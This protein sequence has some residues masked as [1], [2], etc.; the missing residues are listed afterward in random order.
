MRWNSD[1]TY[2]D[3]Y[4]VGKYLKE[5]DDPAFAQQC[6]EAILGAKGSLVQFPRIP[7]DTQTTDTVDVSENKEA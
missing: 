7:V 4:D 3:L 6:R 2:P 1:D 5:H